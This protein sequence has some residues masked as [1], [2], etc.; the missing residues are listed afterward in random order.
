MAFPERQAFLD[1]MVRAGLHAPQQRLLTG[2]IAAIY[3]GEVH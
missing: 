2:G 3:R 1:L